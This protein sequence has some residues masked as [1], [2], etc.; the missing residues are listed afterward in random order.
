MDT[1]KLELNQQQMQ[2]IT[3]ALADLPYRMAEPLMS[4]IRSEVERQLK[5]YETSSDSC[6][7]DG[8]DLTEK[9]S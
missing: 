6:G 4:Y 8:E 1:I 3:G 7:S 2:I 5:E 9:V